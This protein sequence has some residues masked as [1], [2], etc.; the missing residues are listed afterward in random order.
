LDD[1][2]Q[3]LRSVPIAAAEALRPEPGRERRM[4]KAS[5]FEAFRMVPQ[6]R[7]GLSLE[8]SVG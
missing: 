4:K 3:Q 6:K 5:S 7:I 8:G 2:A 1:E